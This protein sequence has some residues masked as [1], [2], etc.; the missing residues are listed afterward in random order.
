MDAT[1]VRK[2]SQEALDQLAA[3]LEQGKSETLK[4]YLT[5]MGRFTHY[6]LGQPDAHCAPEA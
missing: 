3:A 2:V 5:V 4:R 6:S 1:E